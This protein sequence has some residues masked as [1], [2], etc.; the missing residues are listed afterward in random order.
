MN[1]VPLALLGDPR[2]TAEHARAN[3]RECVACEGLGFVADD[4]DRYSERRGHYTVSSS[5]DCEPCVGT[6][7][8]VD[9]LERTEDDMADG[10]TR[11]LAEEDSLI[12]GERAAQVALASL[13]SLSQ[14][15]DD[16]RLLV[17]WA[18]DLPADAMNAISDAVKCTKD[19][20]VSVDALE[21]EII[22]HMERA[23]G[24][25]LLELR[26][27]AEALKSGVL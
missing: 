15:R 25:L 22:A 6:G 23:T 9:D 17:R 7:W 20:S 14:E 1:D 12:V 3:V 13:R 10:G 16:L 2:I 11:R 26:N 21:A 4:E 24:S 19:R 27:N 5:R 18:E 8:V